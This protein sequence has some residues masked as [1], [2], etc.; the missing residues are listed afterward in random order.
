MKF[1]NKLLILMVLLTL[2]SNGVLLVITYVRSREILLQEMRSKVL[3]IAATT[4]R[5]VNAELHE[6]IKAPAD[7]S[8]EAYTSVES[9]LRSARDANRRD[10]VRVKFVYTVRPTGLESDGVASGYI[11]VVDAE[12]RD[13]GEKSAVGDEYEPKDP[14]APLMP[15]DR[16]YVEVASDE[17]GTFL[18]ASSPIRDAAGKPVALLGVDVGIED[19]LAR[20]R[21]LLWIGLG[22]MVIAGAAGA[23]FAAYL[24]RRVTRTLESLNDAVAKVASGDLDAKAPA[25]GDDEFALLGKAFND[26]VPQ[27]RDGMKL[28]ESLALAMEVQQSL[29]PMTPPTVDGLEI[30]GRSI[31]CDETGGDYYDFI[32]LSDVSPHTL[33]ITVGDVTGHGIAAALLMTTARALLRGRASHEGDIAQL[34]THM[35]RHLSRDCQNGRFMTLYYMLVDTRTRHVRWVS[36]GHDPA[37]AYNPATGVFVELAGSDIPM[38]LDPDWVY[39]EFDRGGW[40]DGQIIVIGT[41][42]IWETRDPCKR[43]FGKEALKEIIKANARRSC[44]DIAKAITDTLGRYR[45]GGSQEDDVTLVVMKFVPSS[46]PITE[47]SGSPETARIDAT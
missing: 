29:L 8:S 41:D 6:S 28:K 35:N 46:A 33:A 38:G 42:G 12:E 21:L 23:A 18:S 15:P 32:E 22:A 9:L 27:L 4:A 39:S 30:A 24:S 19:V 11:Y 1:R 16:D 34:V 20:T 13:S 47:D 37:I 3:S 17:F 43:L 2:A 31:Y 14:E 45:Q 40:P 36:A 7:Q 10:D 25:E 5:M 26:M 44:A